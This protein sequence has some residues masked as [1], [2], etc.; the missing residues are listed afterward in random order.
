MNGGVAPSQPEESGGGMESTHHTGWCEPA[1]LTNANVSTL[2][3]YLRSE[4]VS[5]KY[6]WCHYCNIVFSFIDF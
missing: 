2:S 5:A 3:L 4:L 6:Y 1:A